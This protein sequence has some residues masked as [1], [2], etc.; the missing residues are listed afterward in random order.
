M[1]GLPSIR[2]GREGFLLFARFRPTQAMPLAD[3]AD[4]SKLRGDLGKSAVD[5][6]FVRPSTDSDKIN[7]Q[8]S[9]GKEEAVGRNRRTRSFAATFTEPL[10]G[11]QPVGEESF[12]HR[13][14]RVAGG[15]GQ[16][17]EPDRGQSPGGCRCPAEESQKKKRREK[18]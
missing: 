9:S 7:R 4:P 1:A 5:S 13:R 3:L 10:R 8:E 2:C 12:W 15:C 18:R 17:P 11:G 16:T 6:A 14:R